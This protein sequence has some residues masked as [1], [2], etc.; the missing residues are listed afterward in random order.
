MLL[1]IVKLVLI[2]DLRGDRERRGGPDFI[3]PIHIERRL[4]MAQVPNRVPVLSSP[5]KVG[6]RAIIVLLRGVVRVVVI[7]VL[8]HVV[9]DLRLG[10]IGY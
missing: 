1:Q 5:I 9:R 10:Q 6:W 8:G 7:D 3:D 2:G 4:V